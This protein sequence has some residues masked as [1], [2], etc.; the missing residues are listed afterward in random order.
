MT[1]I[2]LKLPGKLIYI[3]IEIEQFRDFCWEMN[4]HML[5]ASIDLQKVIDH[6]EENDLKPF[7]KYFQYLEHFYMN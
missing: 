6:T 1:H 4:D 2:I 7:I 3:K 5:V